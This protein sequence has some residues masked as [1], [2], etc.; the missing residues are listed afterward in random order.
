MAHRKQPWVCTDMSQQYDVAD[1]VKAMS[2]NQDG[3]QEEEV[4]VLPGS[5]W[6]RSYALGSGPGP[7]ECFQKSSVT[8]V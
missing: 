3:Q 7:P 6:L 4:A 1:T 5:F 8:G 2:A